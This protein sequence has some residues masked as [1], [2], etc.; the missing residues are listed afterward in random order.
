LL[1]IGGQIALKRL[2]RIMARDARDALVARFAP[3]PALLQPVRLEAN[4]PHPEILDS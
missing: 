4:H 2:M 1:V 3:A